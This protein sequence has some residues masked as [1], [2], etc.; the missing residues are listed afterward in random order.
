MP[1]YIIESPNATTP[2]NRPIVMRPGNTFTLPADG[3]FAGT[4]PQAFTSYPDNSLA[5]DQN[6]LAGSGKKHKP[7]GSY[8]ILGIWAGADG[9][10]RAPTVADNEVYV[11]FEVTEPLLLSPFVFGS[12]NGKQGFDGIRTMNFQM[13]MLSNANRA[14]RSVRFVDGADIYVKS[15][16]V[17]DFTDSTL[18][19]QYLTPHAS[20][21]LPSRNVI[22]YYELPVYRTN[23]FPRYSRSW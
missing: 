21:M 4:S 10:R 23:N 9:A 2:V 14:W 22:P 5:F 15:A 20:E 3:A 6:R 1:Y 17:T 12:A 8:R 19:F 7:R 16:V 13:N 18:L 11:Q